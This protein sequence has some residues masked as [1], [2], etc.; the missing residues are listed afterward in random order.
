[1]SSIS[2]YGAYIPK[3]RLPL[4]LIGGRPATPGA[5]EKA[6]A[7]FDEDTI[8]MAVAAGSDC[9]AG[10]ER[11]VVDELYFAS[12]TSPYTEKQSAAVIAKA[13]NLRDDAHTVDFSGSLRAAGAALSAA[14]NAVSASPDKTVLVV[15]SDSRLAAPGSPLEQNFGDAAAAFLVSSEGLV[16]FDDC[17][18]VNRE[19]Y[20]IWQ[21]S[22]DRHVQSWEERFVVKHGYNEAVRDA[23]CGLLDK[24]D[25]TISDY[26]HLACYGPDKRSHRAMTSMLG[27]NAGQVAD[28]LF[29]RVGN[30]GTAFAPLLLV[31]ALEQAKAGERILAVFYGDGAQALSLTVTD[32][33]LPGRRPL[34]W[35]LNNRQAVRSYQSYLVSRNLD[36]NADDRQAS[37]GISATVHFRER[38]ADIGF[39]G[40]R[41]NQCDTQQFPATRVCYGCFAKDQF[42]DVPLSALTGR[43]LSYTKDFFFPSSDPPVIAGMCEVDGGARVYLQMADSQDCE[44]RCDLPVEFVFRKIHQAGGKPAYFWKSRLLDQTPEESTNG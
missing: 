4:P 13:L 37:G 29:G 17:F 26:A 24:L 22:R 7:G 31:Q 33:L 3:R 34:D 43:V 23:V 1:M 14:F 39:I 15:A 6:V 25:G 9:L 2:A 21:G 35:Q 36:A 10:T 27:L 32:Q 40:A 42:T 38:D 28:P 16:S 20:D 18:S 5:P 44:L 8:T 11:S 19:M 30:C 41:C 12:T